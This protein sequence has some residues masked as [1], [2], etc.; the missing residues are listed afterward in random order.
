MN[1]EIR[2]ISAAQ[3]HELRH[4]V[5]RPNQPREACAYETDADAGAF[6]QGAFL[7]GKLVGIA[8]WYAELHPQLADVQQYRLRGM[9]V[10][11]AHRGKGVGRSLV[12]AAETALK[13][14]KVTVWWCNARTSA[15]AY[16][17]RIGLQPLGPE[18]DLPPIGPH[19]VMMKRLAPTT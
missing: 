2:P 12:A 16:Y 19:Q 8:S 18:F 5:L 4:R 9:A 13:S 14:K 7:A 11:P 3:T 1:V 15:A 17:H 6:H 10:E